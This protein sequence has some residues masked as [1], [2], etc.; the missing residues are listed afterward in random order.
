MLY[1]D[2]G[3]N[4]DLTTCFPKPLMGYCSG[5]G[6]SFFNNTFINSKS[7]LQGL[8]LYLLNSTRLDNSRMNCLNWYN[9]EPS[10]SSWNSGLLSCPCLYRQGIS[11]FRFRTT[12]AGGSS[13]ISLLRSTSLSRFKAGI[14]CVYY[15]KNQFLE[16]FQERAW[17][18]ASS[19]SDPELDAFETC[20]NGV[21]DPQFCSMYMEKRFPISCRNYRPLVPGWMFGDPHITTLDGLSYTFNGLGDF[22]LV[23]ASAEN[24]NFILQGRT[25]Q[26]GTAQATNFAAFA[27]QY[28]SSNGSVTVEWYLE[29]DGSITTRI[30]GQN[31]SFTSSEDMDAEINDTNPTV[32]LLKNDSITATFEGILS[33]SVSQYS[34]MFS[35]VSNLPNEFLGKTKGL[36]GTWNNNQSDDF[37]RPDGTT[38]PSD[39][40]EQAIYNYGLLYLDLKFS[41]NKIRCRKFRSCVHNS[42]AQSST[43]ARNQAEDPHWLLNFIFFSSSYVL[44][45][46]A[47]LT[48]GIYDQ[49]CVT[50]CMQDKFEPTSVGKKAWILLSECAI[51][52]TGHKREAKENNLFTI[53]QV[54]ERSVFIPIFFRDLIAQN[55]TQYRELQTLC[56]NNTGCIF[57]AMSTNNT[58]VG[59]ATL[60][61]SDS[62]Q[63]VNETLNAIPPEIIGNTTIQTFM[64]TSITVNYTSNEM[65]V[66]FSG[67]PNTSTDIYLCE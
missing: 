33:V 11:D 26:T 28:T 50:V 32:F 37:M 6:D 16:G 34:G 10:P 38:I 42:D 7:D 46:T 40:S 61:V 12:K 19:K 67:N 21:D 14:R 22:T 53:V 30:N 66:T 24:I 4:W 18:S 62:L 60:S 48:F 1:K 20:C 35:A 31:V 39:S 36:L 44:Y 13:T 49:L 23:N 5:N 41:D 45:V 57:D 58:N 3:M 52:C 8:K 25:V 27:A 9:A 59:L 15:R 2:G 29:S 56:G 51:V 55:S 63:A 54:L 64:S 43:H 17:I 65:D 47:F